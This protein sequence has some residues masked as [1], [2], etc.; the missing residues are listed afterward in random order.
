MATQH[1][2]RSG[3]VYPHSSSRPTAALFAVFDNLS[4]APL[5]ARLWL[6]RANGRPGYPLRPLWRAYVASFVLN[7]GS[8]NDLI[9]LLRRDR[10]LRRLCGFGSQLPHRTTF[11]RFITRLSHHPELVEESLGAVTNRLRELL[12]DLGSEVAI[13]STTVR[14]HSNP[15]RHT[16]SDP[17]ASWT[18]KNSAQAKEGGKEW[19]FGYK[20]HMVADANHG[21]PLAVKVTTA[22][23]NDSPTLPGLM[24]WTRGQFPWFQPRAAIADRGYDAMTNFRHL[25][26]NGTLPVIKIRWQ[27]RG[28]LREGIYTR[29]GIPTCLGRV[30]M[31]YVRTDGDGRHLYR[32]RA[33][34]CELAQSTAGMAPHCRD[35]VWE[36]PGQS[37]NLRLFGP[38][39]RQSPEWQAL[40]AKRQSVERTF[41]SLKQSRRLE[42]HCVRGLRQ[43]RL[44]ALM[45]VLVYQ[46]TALASALAGAMPWLR[47]MV[48]KVA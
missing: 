42:R 36:D 6:Y 32:C 7:L 19:R 23:V 1:C 5:L 28:K 14:T 12:P 22:K 25:H 46:A 27:G 24:D 3:T 17:E 41:K 18:P 37:Q 9:R 10:E 4:D 2:S 15:N 35:E 30:P 31:D 8:T 45:A 40:Y 26:D 16:V 21:L 11:N 38:I 34:G 33:G 29:D 43:V 44:H 47:W 13:D 39:R 20:L 48:A